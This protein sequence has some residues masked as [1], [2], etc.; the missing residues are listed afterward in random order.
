MGF[1]F[2]K[3]MDCIGN[4]VGCSKVNHSLFDDLSDGEL[5]VLNENRKKYNFKKG[6]YL[7]QEGDDLHG[8]ICLNQ[9]KVKLVKK[10]KIEEEF[11]VSLHKTVD[12]VGFDDLMSG[13]DASTTAIALNDVSVC[14]ITKEQFF[15]VIRGNS[16][17]AIKIIENQ[18]QKAIHYQDKL[19]NIAQSNLSSRLAFALIEL[20]EFYGFEKD[21][22]TLAV[23]MKR[24]EIAA[25]SSMNTA[26]AIRTLAKFKDEEVIDFDKKKIVIL[27]RQILNSFL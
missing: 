3:I 13:A 26:N 6:D 19:L 20:I 7:Y 15:K 22:K 12:F 9:G 17:L 4:C 2:E 10:G 16:N 14:I 18:S 1:F 24:R 27:N 21:G 5:K 25:I 23:Q 8:L 11:I